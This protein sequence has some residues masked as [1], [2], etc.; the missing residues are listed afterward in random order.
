MSESNNRLMAKKAADIV[1][2][3]VATHNLS[4]DELAVL[5]ASVRKSLE[6]VEQSASGEAAEPANERP[7]AAAIRK[8]ITRETL[9]SFIDGKPYKVL[10]RHLSRHGLTPDAYRA[11][12]GLPNDY[13]MTAASYSA[14]RA[15]LAKESHF[16]EKRVK[17]AKKVAR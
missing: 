3:Y 2:A 10:K 14:T 5:I 17:S 16:G 12:Y 6:N 13:P 7:S 9:I 4:P 8:S 1:S 11:R 15:R